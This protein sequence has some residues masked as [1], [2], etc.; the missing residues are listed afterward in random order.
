MKQVPEQLQ[1]P[2]DIA[3]CHAANIIIYVFSLEDL[4]NPID[5]GFIERPNA[6]ANFIVVNGTAYEM[7]DHVFLT[8]P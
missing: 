8:T 6:D 4:Q 5:A 7:K 2:E 1:K 3:F